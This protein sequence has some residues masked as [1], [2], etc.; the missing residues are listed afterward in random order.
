MKTCVYSE[1]DWRQQFQNKHSFVKD[2]HEVMRM[3]GVST[4][5]CGTVCLFKEIS[6]VKCMSAAMACEEVNVF[7]MQIFIHPRLQYV[8][9]L[10]LDK[11]LIIWKIRWSYLHKFYMI[12]FVLILCAVLV[13]IPQ[14]LC[15]PQLLNELYKY[16]LYCTELWLCWWG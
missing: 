14:Y 2:L 4:L 16:L 13:T 12:W 15:K 10:N 8:K 1:H 11:P 5:Q 7:S 3:S 9:Y 6:S